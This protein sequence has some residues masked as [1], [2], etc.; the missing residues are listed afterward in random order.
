M[1]IYF[2]INR[3]I[4]YINTSK[5]TMYNNS[6]S[7]SFN[8]YYSIN[9]FRSP[10]NLQL[11]PIPT[12]N[13][14][15]K[16]LTPNLNCPNP[17]YLHLSP[18]PN[19]LHLSPTPNCPNIIVPNYIQH[20][21]PNWNKQ[22]VIVNEKKTN[23]LG[24]LAKGEKDSKCLNSKKEKLVENT[25]KKEKVGRKKKAKVLDDKK[26]LSLFSRMRFPAN[27][28]N[29]ILK[30]KSVDA[31]DCLPCHE[32]L[33][34]FKH[35]T[36]I[37][38]QTFNLQSMAIKRNKEGSNKFLEEYKLDDTGTI[39]IVSSTGKKVS[40]LHS[41]NNRDSLVEIN[42]NSCVNRD[43]ENTK[44]GLTEILVYFMHNLMSDHKS[45]IMLKD[46]LN[47]R[48]YQR[49]CYVL[50]TKFQLKSTKWN[51]EVNIEQII[52]NLTTQK[53]KIVINNGTSDDRKRIDRNNKTTIFD[54]FKELYME[55]DSYRKN[56][57]HVFEFQL[58]QSMIEQVKNH[59]ENNNNKKDFY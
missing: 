45:R 54:C 24:K 12:R 55:S 22:G 17:N 49:L 52:S 36:N 3:S 39:S 26:K 27:A 5:E 33:H 41:F 53:S 57:A 6:T 58:P 48:T 23:Q 4:H 11:S 9:A 10:T 18:N 16:T 21:S 20:S 1:F 32:K 8:Q 43:I 51:K 29:F 37:L 34:L 25:K 30:V 46:K 28:T 31:I 59:L 7:T 56:V 42:F 19:Y 35:L 40:K 47:L 2:F 15:A 13:Y 44:Y 50:L 14:L 38:A